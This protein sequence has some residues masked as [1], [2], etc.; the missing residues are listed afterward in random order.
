MLSLFCVLIFLKVVKKILRYLKG[1]EDMSLWYPRGCKLDLI[2]YIDADFVRNKVYR[3]STSR[4]AQFKGQVLFHGAQWNK[5][6]ASLSM[7]AVEYNKK[8]WLAIDEYYYRPQCPRQTRR[9]QPRFVP[10][11]QEKMSN[12]YCYVAFNTETH[13]DRDER[14]QLIAECCKHK[15][16]RPI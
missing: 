15:L 16:I 11:Y 7:T 2:G 12:Y 8:Y 9:W 1:I 14:R 5:T 6:S 13:L 3:K 4:M 10:H